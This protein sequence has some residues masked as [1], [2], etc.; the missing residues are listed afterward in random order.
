MPS[1]LIILGRGSLKEQC[2]F[3]KEVWATVSVLGDKSFQ[4][5]PY[6]KLF[7]FDRWNADKYPDWPDDWKP[8]QIA[9][10]RE[11][12]IVGVGTYPYVTEAYPLFKVRKR[13]GS[14]FFMNSISFM[15]ALALYEGY[16][17]IKLWGVWGPCDT[18]NYLVGRRYVSYWLGVATGMGVK[19]KLC[20][21]WDIWEDCYVPE[22]VS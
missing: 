18:M 11:L 4:D 19:W 9:K 17:D 1:E 5:K 7:I 13:F 3:D 10:K 15:L 22:T 20:P 16:E 21:D 12:P 2:P 8:M 14:L 6:S